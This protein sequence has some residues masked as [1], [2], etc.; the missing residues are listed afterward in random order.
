MTINDLYS[1]SQQ[2]HEIDS[3]SIEWKMNKTPSIDFIASLIAVVTSLFTILF[4]CERA[5]QTHKL[6]IDGKWNWMHCGR[7]EPYRPQLSISLTMSL[8]KI[9][10][11]NC[12]CRTTKTKNSFC[13]EKISGFVCLWFRRAKIFVV[14]LL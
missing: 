14:I 4:Y 9:S 10:Q 13:L 1:H 11:M 8:L 2:W 12:L 7:C 6:Q 3:S 5:N